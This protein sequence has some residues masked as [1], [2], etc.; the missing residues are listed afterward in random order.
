[1]Q[2]ITICF[3]A[4]R[5]THRT[6][7]QVMQAGHLQPLSKEMLLYTGLCLENGQRDGSDGDRN[8]AHFFMLKQQ[9]KQRKNGRKVATMLKYLLDVSISKQFF[10]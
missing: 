1:M 2:N 6:D 7:V 10:S 4:D 8:D 3:T 5:Q 9:N